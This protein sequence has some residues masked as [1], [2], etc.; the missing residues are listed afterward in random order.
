MLNG[1]SSKQVQ[2]CYSGVFQKAQSEQPRSA[3]PWSCLLTCWCPWPRPRTR[4]A[5][6]SPAWCSRRITCHLNAASGSSLVWSLSLSQCILSGFVLSTCKKIHP[7]LNSWSCHKWLQ[8]SF[9]HLPGE[10]FYVTTR[11]K[12]MVKNLENPSSKGT[13]NLMAMHGWN[14]TQIRTQLQVWGLLCIKENRT[15]AALQGFFKESVLGRCS[16]TRLSLQY[17]SGNKAWAKG[18][19]RVGN[20]TRARFWGQTKASLSTCSRADTDSNTGPHVGE[21]LV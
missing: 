10:S 1:S 14:H 7:L 4:S 8:K 16:Q 21:S 6:R 2:T 18:K 12:I 17:S 13:R 5:L 20:E 11:M 15:V 9:Q 3:S 19:V